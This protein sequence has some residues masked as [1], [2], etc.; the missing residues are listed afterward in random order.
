MLDG[1]AATQVVPVKDKPGGPMFEDVI[2][3]IPVP[4]FTDVTHV[5]GMADE[6]A[7]QTAAL[8]R[9]AETAHGALTWAIR[10]REYESFL[11]EVG[12][13]HLAHIATSL[14]LMVVLGVGFLVLAVYQAM[15]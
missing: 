14:R 11:F 6:A 8:G 1:E 4:Q 3:E 10:K 12:N 9:I 5:R 13:N 15:Q 2:R 7:D